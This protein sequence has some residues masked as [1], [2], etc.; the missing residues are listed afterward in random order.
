MEAYEEFDKTITQIMLHAEKNVGS[1][2]WGG[3]H[4]HQN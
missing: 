1:Y 3:Y 2:L 4:F